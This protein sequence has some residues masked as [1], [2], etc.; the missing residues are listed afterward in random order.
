M[1][2]SWLNINKI[3]YKHLYRGENNKA[4]ISF[5]KSI[6]IKKTA[7]GYEGISRI[8]SNKNDYVKVIIFSEA[9]LSLGPINPGELH[10]SR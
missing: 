6:R 2:V 5:Y 9:S 10:F 7:R 3:G 8:Y 4:L 1:K